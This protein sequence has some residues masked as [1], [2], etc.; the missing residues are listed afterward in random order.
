[1]DG[2]AY[3]YRARPDLLDPLAP[4]WFDLVLRGYG[5]QAV[6][7]YA[8]GEPGDEV[9]EF[10]IKL[11]GYDRSQVDAYVARRRGRVSDGPVGG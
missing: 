8:G 11:R 7:A 2:P 1:M 6:D 10:P 5:Q 3:V 9:P 4:P